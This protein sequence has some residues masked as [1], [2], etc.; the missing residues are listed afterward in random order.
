[1][2]VGTHGAASITRAWLER[3]D[4]ELALIANG[5]DDGP[6]DG[7]LRHL[8]PGMP[9]PTHFCF[10][11]G[12]LSGWSPPIATQSPS[13]LERRITLG[14]GLKELAEAIVALEVPSA[15]VSKI[16]AALARNL[17]ALSAH[18][19]KL[20]L[21]EPPDLGGCTF[22]ELALA[23][24]YLRH[25]R[26]FNRALA[27][28]SK[29]LGTQGR[30]V[31][32]AMGE[33]RFVS[34]L[35]E[36]GRVLASSAKIDAARDDARVS[37]LYLTDVPLRPDQLIALDELD[38]EHRRDVLSVLN[39]DSA[40]SLEATYALRSADVIVYGP[41]SPFTSLFP[42][43]LTRGVR[44]SIERSKARVRLFVV[45]LRQ[46]SDALGWSDADLVDC[47]LRQ[48]GDPHNIRHLITHVLV[49][50]YATHR[51]DG[52]PEGDRT[53]HGASR[54]VEWLAEEVEDLRHPGVHAGAHVVERALSVL[55]S[56]AS[57]S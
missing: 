41:G 52:V 13:W 8:L 49:D 36:D 37:A 3:S 35:G 56:S 45:N 57:R 51:A 46:A 20:A 11:L 31:N 22:G 1:M 6:G 33:G 4:V 7:T 34:A 14:S 10:Q 43:F 30:L 2:F 44:R 50:P 12:L 15:A 19:N 32:V 54:H 39:S 55:D 25:D 21:D 28:F 16:P 9:S 38:E 40:V 17:R 29:R 47:A 42:S 26:D 23:G 48:L 27:R 5:Y 24:A 18:L 53:A